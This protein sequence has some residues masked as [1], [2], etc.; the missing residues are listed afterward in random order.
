MSL[1]R[2]S[3]TFVAADIEHQAGLFEQPKRINVA[4][5]RAEKMLIVVGNPT[6]M[7]QD[8]IWSEWVQFCLQSGLWY[9]EDGSD[10]NATNE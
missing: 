6:L 10:E 2:S 3:E 5:T 1:T 4:L 7:K 8:P 9:G